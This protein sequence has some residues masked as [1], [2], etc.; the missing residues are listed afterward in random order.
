MKNFLL[1]FA[2]VLVANL[3]FAQTVTVSP[4]TTPLVF[5]DEPLTVTITASDVSGITT[6]E[7]F[8]TASP[9]TPLITL[10]PTI[11]A[12]VI[13]TVTFTISSS[14]PSADV[15][16]DPATNQLFGIFSD[17]TT[18]LAYAIIDA[19]LP[20]ELSSFE[21]KST[22]EAVALSW[23][24]A[25]ELN[26]DFF[27]VERSFD[28]E[29][30]DAL[31]KVQGAGESYEEIHYS[32]EDVNALRAASSNTAYYRLMQTD[33]DGTST[34]SEVVAVTLEGGKGFE[35]TNVATVDGRVEVNFATPQEGSTTVSVFDLNGRQVGTTTLQAVEGFNNA[36][37]NMN[38]NQNGIYLVR[39]TNGEHVAVRKFMN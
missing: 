15:I 23:T 37:I 19:K 2:F 12:G 28:G 6:F 27:T 34:Y 16:L 21:A 25:M 22:N 26:N 14:D 1:F 7:L 13:S 29:K 10:T 9:T 33:F 30:F 38:T 5:G 18:T 11:I 35:V 4:S 8:S 3:S 32:F 17:G 31:G 39:I 20:V 36:T 24:T